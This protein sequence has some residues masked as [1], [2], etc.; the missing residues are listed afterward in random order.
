MKIDHDVE[1][2]LSNS[3]T[4]GSLLFLPPTQLERSLYLKVNKALEAI[5]GKWN[6]KQKAHVFDYDPADAVDQIILTGEFIDPKKELGF[7]ATPPEI[8]KQ[9]VNT[10]TICEGDSVL[11]PSAGDGSIAEHV[12]VD[13]DCLTLVEVDSGRFSKL[14]KK[15]PEAHTFH[16]DFLKWTPDRKFDHVRMN[17]PFSKQQD[18]DHVTRA[19]GMLADGGSLAAIM[20]AGVLFR[21]N[22]KIVEFRE[23]VEAH[24]GNIDALPEGA[25]KESGTNVRTCIVTMLK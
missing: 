21:E 1:M 18:I 16:I 13:P 3:R 6:R 11:E 5:G 9:L 15:F 17:P 2:V 12:P 8:A 14:C 22:R 19:F 25:F 7:F 20:S 4:E 23:L 10:Y 24:G